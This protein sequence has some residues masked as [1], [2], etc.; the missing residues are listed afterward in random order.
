M[1]CS[2]IKDRLRLYQKE[3][4]SEKSLDLV[5]EH[6]E[7]CSTCSE[8][9]TDACKLKEKQED[10]Y[11]AV[12]KKIKK[13]NKKRIL[14]VASLVLLLCLYISN[15]A[16]AKINDEPLITIYSKE[17]SI[18]KSSYTI[19]VSLGFV[20]HDYNIK[21]GK[22]YSVVKP[23][24]SKANV[25]ISLTTEQYNSLMKQLAAV[26]RYVDPN[27]NENSYKREIFAHAKIF[28]IVEKKMKVIIV[29]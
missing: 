21:Y 5:K 16:A 29:K 4:I 18:G 6:I 1:D 17:T 3:D 11:K 9:F 2:V 10:N 12:V 7:N 13:S 25:G 22:N 14:M 26:E 15:F 24:F 28:D 23:W 27:N 19:R 20:V 8:L